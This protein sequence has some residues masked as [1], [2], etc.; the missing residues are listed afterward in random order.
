MAFMQN[1]GFNN[2]NNNNF[3]GE[4]KKTNFGIGRIWGSDGTLDVAIWKNQSGVSV[5]LM[6]KQAV[7]K[8]PSTG[9]NVFENKAPNELP[10]MYMNLSQARTFLECVNMTPRNELGNIN[11]VIGGERS[12]RKLTVNGQGSAIKITIEDPKIGSRTITL[13]ATTAGPK[14]IHADFLNLTDFIRKGFEKALTNKLDPEEFGLSSN[15]NDDD[16]FI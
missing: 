14:N 1:N 11:F 5:T 3:Q 4:K 15:D 13:E 2:S 16:N 6:I 8:D 9:A 12:P 7:G 10:R